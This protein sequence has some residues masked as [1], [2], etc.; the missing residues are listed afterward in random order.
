MERR[1]G[2]RT[3]HLSIHPRGGGGLSSRAFSPPQ[4]LRSRRALKNLQPFQ[5]GSLLDFFFVFHPFLPPT[6]SMPARIERGLRPFQTS[7]S[8]PAHLRFVIFFLYRLRLLFLTKPDP[9]KSGDPACTTYSI[10]SVH[11]V[12]STIFFQREHANSCKGG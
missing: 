4:F 7:I 3:S 2:R 9:R 1:K 10:R 8:L 5:E 6:L 12:P 11:F